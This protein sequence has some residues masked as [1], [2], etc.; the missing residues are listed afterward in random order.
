ME[1]WRTDQA[2][3]TES[4][5]EDLLR[6]SLHR[7]VDADPAGFQML[8]NNLFSYLDIVYRPPSNIDVTCEHSYSLTGFLINATVAVIGQHI[9]QLVRRMCDGSLEEADPSP[10]VSILALLI[11]SEPRH[12]KV[13]FTSEG[14]IHYFLPRHYRNYC[15]P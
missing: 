2:Y 9:I 7:T 4:L 11:Q 15:L 8:L 14:Q 5:G 3:V 1:S 6:D 12:Y 13:G 10:L